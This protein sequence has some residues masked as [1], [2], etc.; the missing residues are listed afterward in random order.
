MTAMHTSIGEYLTALAA[1]GKARCT[2]EV[3]G[4]RSLSE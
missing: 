1:E 2:V 3:Y 4:A